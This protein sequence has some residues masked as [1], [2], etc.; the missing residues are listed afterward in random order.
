LKY[1]VKLTTYIVT[2]GENAIR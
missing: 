1:K 2:S